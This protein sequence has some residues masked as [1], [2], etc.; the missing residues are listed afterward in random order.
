M[1]LLYADGMIDIFVKNQ[2]NMTQVFLQERI[3]K[4]FKKFFC[5]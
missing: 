5:D 1:M 4:K 3:Q 2:N